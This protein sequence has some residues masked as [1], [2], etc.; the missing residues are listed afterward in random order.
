MLCRP[1]HANI[2]KTMANIFHPSPGNHLA[3]GSRQGTVCASII[4]EQQ[5]FY[6]CGVDFK[7]NYHLEV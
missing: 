6:N 3:V 5:A 4:T 2:L 1:G 7:V